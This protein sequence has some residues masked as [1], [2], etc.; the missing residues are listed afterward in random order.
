ML[1]PDCLHHLAGRTISC[2]GVLLILALHS[3]PATGPKDLILTGPQ[4]QK[5]LQQLQ[6]AVSGCLRLDFDENT[7]NVTCHR[8][9]KA[10]NRHDVSL[11]RQAKRLKEIIGDHTVIVHV[12]ASDSMV[13]ST[14]RVTFGGSYLGNSFTG[15]R[16]YAPDDAFTLVPIVMAKQQVDPQTDAKIS[17]Y[18]QKPG[19][20]VLH[21][22]TESYAAAKYAQKDNI[23]DTAGILYYDYA[24]GRATPQSG[25]IYTRQLDSLRHETA[26]PGKV[27]FVDYFIRAGSCGQEKIIRT[28]YKNQNI[29]PSPLPLFLVHK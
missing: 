21:E 23:A 8:V 12:S 18:Y 27:F 25:P 11:T 14:G 28:L 17:D 1:V 22:V 20:D 15:A 13:T 24:H 10:N 2:S 19:A 16:G 6:A 5:A 29:R 4:R 26:D 9:Q 3:L 7:G